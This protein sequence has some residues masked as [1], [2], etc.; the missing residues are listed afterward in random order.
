MKKLHGMMMV[1]SWGVLTTLGV[2][3]ARY[4]RILFGG[5][6]PQTGTLEVSKAWFEIHR[7]FQTIATTETI[8]FAAFDPP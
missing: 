5:K 3:T 4:R 2:I 1:S 8:S 6:N 7:L